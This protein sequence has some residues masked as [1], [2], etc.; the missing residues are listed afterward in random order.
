MLYTYVSYYMDSTT[1]VTTGIVITI[2]I[3]LGFFSWFYFRS[4]LAM[5]AP[6]GA[7]PLPV[8]VVPPLTQSGGGFDT[9]RIQ[10]TPDGKG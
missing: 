3:V 4:P 8:L 9:I 1:K 2:A 10:P 6:V 5:P 7:A